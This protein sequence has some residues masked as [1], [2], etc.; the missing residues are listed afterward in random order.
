MQASEGIRKSRGAATASKAIAKAT[1]VERGID[2][3]GTMMSVTIQ[4]VARDMA[5]QMTTGIGGTGTADLIVS[6]APQGIMTEIVE[7]M[8]T[9]TDRACMIAIILKTTE[10]ESSITAPRA[11]A[12]MREMLTRAP[13]RAIQTLRGKYPGMRRWRPLSA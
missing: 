5:I 3:T 12:S 9:E 6:G 7:T 2:M 10:A 4:G 11:A 1:E 8:H 13:R